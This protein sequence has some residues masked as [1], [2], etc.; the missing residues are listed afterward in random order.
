MPVKPSKVDPSPYMKLILLTALLNLILPLFA[1]SETASISPSRIQ[2]IG[3]QANLFKA[4][5]LDQSPYLQAG[6]YNLTFDDGPA[7]KSTALILNILRKYQ[8][9]ANF[10]WLGKSFESHQDL[11]KQA[12]MDGHVLG[13]H[14]YSHPSFQLLSLEQA[15]R[16]IDKSMQAFEKFVG[17]RPKLFRFPFGAFDVVNLAKR[18]SLLELAQKKEMSVFEWNMPG[19]DWIYQ[20]VPD[21]QKNMQ[22]Q[23]AQHDRGIIL[24]HDTHMHTARFLEPLLLELNTRKLKT[25]VFQAN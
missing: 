11:I 10:F 21:L 4:G 19:K 5:S 7:D 16:E 9:K 2:S 6:E 8:V 18:Q 25:V 20:N 24:L 13:L 1:Q 22:L 14:S 15:T 23:L 3:N 12:Q 17:F